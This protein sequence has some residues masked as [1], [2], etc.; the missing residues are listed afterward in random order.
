MLKLSLAVCPRGIFWGNLHTAALLHQ[1]QSPGKPAHCQVV[2]AP[3]SAFATARR[4]GL[5]HVQHGVGRQICFGQADGASPGHGSK[6]VISSARPGPPCPRGRS[7]AA[8]HRPAAPGP[9]QIAEP[10]SLLQASSRAPKCYGIAVSSVV[11]LGSMPTSP[12]TTARLD[13]NWY[14]RA[15]LRRWERSSGSLGSMPEWRSRIRARCG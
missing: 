3:R 13:S 12:T 14:G 2:G 8:S 11:E 9:T 5:R 4:H 6:T 7:G 15:G 1:G 10:S